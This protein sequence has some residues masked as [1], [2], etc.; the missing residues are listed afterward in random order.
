[1][2]R[3]IILLSGLFMCRQG[4]FCVGRVA[5]SFFQEFQYV[6]RFVIMLAGF[7]LCRPVCYYVGRVVITSAGLLLGQQGCYYV[8]SV[9]I[10]LVWLLLCWHDCYNIDIVVSTWCWICNNFPAVFFKFNSPILRLTS[11][12]VIINVSFF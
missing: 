10:M 4:F 6:D 7:L 3:V 5:S 9:V 2:F 12:I 8:G 1:M 11:F